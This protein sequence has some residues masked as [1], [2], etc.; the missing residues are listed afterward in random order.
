[1][2][3]AS[4]SHAALV[5]G[6]ALG[7]AAA[8]AQTLENGTGSAPSQQLATPPGASPLN[9]PDAMKRDLEARHQAR[10]ARTPRRRHHAPQP[11]NDLAQTLPP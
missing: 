11:G 6:L 5:L 9:Q 2:R 8:S 3:I 1:M 10:A 4:I 7:G